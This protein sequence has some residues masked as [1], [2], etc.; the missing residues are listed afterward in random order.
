MADMS[1]QLPVTLTTLSLAA[2]VG[3]AT[4]GIAYGLLTRRNG[5]PGPA[6]LPLIGNLTQVARCGNMTT[7]LNQMREKYGDVSLD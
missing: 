5:L 3:V 2:A 4:V 7:F 1:K 6:P